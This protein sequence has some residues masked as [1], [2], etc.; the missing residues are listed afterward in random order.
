[1]A[2]TSSVY[3]KLDGGGFHKVLDNFFCWYVCA[4]RLRSG[5][6]VI[7]EYG[8]RIYRVDAVRG[9]KKL[10]FTNPA[11]TRHFHFTAVDPFTND[12]YT[13]LG[14]ALKRY[15]GFGLTGIMRSQDFGKQW[16][17]L[18]KTTVGSDA[19]DRQPTAIFFDGDRVYFGTDSKPHG[20]FVLDRNE[21]EFEQIFYMSDLLRSW[22][23]GNREEERIVLGAF[24]RFRKR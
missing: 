20:I 17:W 21:N 11:G 13:S 24:A 19:I 9:E 8:S 15:A 12:I 16:D 7:G 23:T 2:D 5:H 14:D 18:Y 3:L 1:L 4:S 10:F 22:F 6:F